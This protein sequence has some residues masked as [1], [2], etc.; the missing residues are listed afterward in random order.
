VLHAGLRRLKEKFGYIGDARG[1]GLVPGVEIVANCETKEPEFA[2]ARGV[3]V[4]LPL[5]C[6]GKSRHSWELRRDVSHCSAHHHHEGGLEQGL[7]L[8]EEAFA[9]TEETMPHPELAPQKSRIT[10]PTHPRPVLFFALLER[11]VPDT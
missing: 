6:L 1:R 3:S 10:P 2:L 9:S 4:P 5:V 7:A 8:L 11:S